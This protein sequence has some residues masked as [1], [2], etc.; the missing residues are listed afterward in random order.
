[1]F[2]EC[3][4]LHHAADAWALTA[5]HVR[6]VRRPWARVPKTVAGRNPIACS[7]CGATAPSKRPESKTSPE[8]PEC[9]LMT[10]HS[11]RKPTVLH[12]AKCLPGLSNPVSATAAFRRRRSLQQVI[13]HI[14]GQDR[15]FDVAFASR[16]APNS[17]GFMFPDSSV[18]SNSRRRSRNRK[19]SARLRGKLFHTSGNAGG[20]PAPMSCIS[21]AVTAASPRLIT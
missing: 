6:C 12:A 15:P 16:S 10:E 1:M 18:C 8:N 19:R 11:I 4:D 2:P 21:D 14:P 5:R 17:T 20:R 9:R 3:R 7:A 13:G